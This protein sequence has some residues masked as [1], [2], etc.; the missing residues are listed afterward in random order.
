MLYHFTYM[1]SKNNEQRK[2]TQGNEDQTDGGLRKSM[3]GN[4]VD[5]IVI[6]LHGDRRLL[7]LVWWSHCKLFKCWITTLYT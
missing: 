4:I 2:K 3:K 7:D 5:N 1:K 6:S